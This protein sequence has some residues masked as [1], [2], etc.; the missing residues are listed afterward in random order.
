ML[1]HNFFVHTEETEW[2]NFSA[3]LMT[4]SLT[5][6]SFLITE[7]YSIYLQIHSY[8]TILICSFWFPNAW[9]Y[10]LSLSFLI[11]ELHFFCPLPVRCCHQLCWWLL[12]HSAALQGQKMLAG[13]GEFRGLS[14]I[15]RASG[16]VTNLKPNFLSQKWPEVISESFLAA[17]HEWK[18]KLPNLFFFFFLRT[19]P[20]KAFLEIFQ[21]TTPSP[22]KSPLMAGRGEDLPCW[23][24][25]LF[26]LFPVHVTFQFVPLKQ[27]KRTT[28]NNKTLVKPQSLSTEMEN[29]LG[30]K[31]N[32]EPF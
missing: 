21:Q 32:P 22:C 15:G 24:S 11:T 9:Q 31:S 5:D 18:L 20:V 2:N 25:S 7:V 13:P 28:T 4:I 26:F 17:M 14:F 10:S 12:G 16:T 6:L 8:N 29:C 1:L 30:N 23:Y 19:S 27:K 3:P